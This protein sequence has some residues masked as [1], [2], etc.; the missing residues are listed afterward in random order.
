[1]YTSWSRGSR[2]G[3]FGRIR[4]RSVRI[5][6]QDPDPLISKSDSHPRKNYLKIEEQ[7]I[8]EII[9]GLGCCIHLRVWDSK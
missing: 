1:M 2:S 8:I 7:K 5:L 3:Y 6:I 9:A 4:I